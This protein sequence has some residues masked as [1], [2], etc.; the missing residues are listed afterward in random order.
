MQI[1]SAE[2]KELEKLPESLKGQFSELEKELEHLIQTEDANVV[3]LYSRRCLEVIITDLC[4][5]ELGRPRKT[6]PLK[7]IIDK[8]NR[9]DKVPSHIISSMH[10]L[11]SLSTYGTHPKDFDPE[12]VKPVLNNLTTIIKWY[13]KYKDTRKANEVKPE[14]ARY[15][16]KV[17]DTISDDTRKSKKRLIIL[18]SG[19]LL[20]CVLVIIGLVLFNVIGSK[21]QAEVDTDLEKSI[22]VLP[23]HNFSGD[24]D[25]EYMSD[26]LTDEIINHLYKIKSFDKVVSLN[27]VLTYKGTDKRLPQIASELKVDYILEG[28]YKK[29]GEQVR[30]TAQ[31]IEPKNDRHLWQNEYDK[32]YMEIIAI[33]ADIALKIADQIKAFITDAEKQN[34]QKIPTTNQEAYDFLQQAIIHLSTSDSS[35]D[36]NRFLKKGKDLTLKAIELDPYYSDAYAWAGLYSLYEG[37]FAGNKEMSEATLNALPFIENALELDQNNGIAHFIMGN[38]NEWGRWDYIKAEKE[39]LKSIEL[40]PNRV[41]NYNLI[42]EFYIKM[43]RPDNAIPLLK[44]VYESDLNTRGNLIAKSY[45][46]SGNKKEAYDSLNKFAESCEEY[47]YKWVGEGFIWLEDYDYA[48]LYLESALKSKDSQ[49]FLPRFQACLALVYHKTKKYQQAQAIINQLI[50][51]SKETSVGSPEYFAGW[52]YS[53][54]GEVDSAFYWLE[55]A[56]NKHSP[57]MPFLKVTPVFKNLKDDDR[58]WDLYARTGHKAYDEYMQETR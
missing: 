56:Y 23:F 22:A 48:K 12:Q 58:Y 33:Q 42:G 13:L 35:T 4:E 36:I 5:C 2:I 50:N 19:L 9:E 47:M 40:L 57:E 55:K 16:S 3:M 7:G 11:N 53:G 26:G 38:I 45:I 15:E 43:N 8:L 41:D 51:K 46:L 21:K 28:T 44:K 14:E 27:S 49:M 37:A 10:S 52:Y 6:E 31:L 24:P 30:V 29:I 25:Q 34:I 54:I 1:W 39:Y 20:A 32:P 17:T 18:F